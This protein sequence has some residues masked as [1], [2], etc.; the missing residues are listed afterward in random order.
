[1]G[2]ARIAEV[3]DLMRQGGI[4]LYELDPAEGLQPGSDM[5]IS[6]GG[7]GTFLTAA[8]Y[9]YDAGIPILGVNL[10]RMGFLSGARLDEIADRIADGDYRIEERQVLEAS[11]MYAINEMSLCR[12]GTETI[13]VEVSVDGCRF[14]TY[15]ADGVLVSTTSG[16][17]AYNLSIG[18]PICAPGSK[19]L[20]IS[21]IAPHNLGVRPLVIP[22]SSRIVMKVIARHGGAVFSCDNRSTDVPNGFAVDISLAERSL[23]CITMGNTGFMDALRSRFFWGMDVRNTT[24]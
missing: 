14:P 13:G 20:V 16:S 17:T 3:F 6:F 24:D 5:L 19:V 2:N 22:D 23:K 8:Q 4:D 1:M 21:P 18:G 9:A 15:W 11:G 12:V 10:G 7:D